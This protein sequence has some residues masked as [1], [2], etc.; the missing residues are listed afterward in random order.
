MKKST[1]R[2][3]VAI[4]SIAI[5]VSVSLSGCAVQHDN[6]IVISLGSEPNSLD[7]AISLTTDA[8]SYI[9]C[10][11]EG[12]LNLDE[13][14]NLIDGAADEWSANST[15]TEYKFHIREDAH[16][17][18]GEKL[19]AEDFLYAWL[20][21]LAPETASGWASFLYYIKNAAA[22]NAGECTAEEVGV[23]AED[24]YL[25]V[26]MESPCA[27]FASMTAIQP[28]FPVYAKSIEEN[29]A[30]WSNHANSLISN[31]AFKLKQWNH[32]NNIVIESNK[33]YWDR[34]KIKTNEIRFDLLE[35]ASVAIN[36]YEA[37][38]LFYLENILTVNEMAQIDDVEVDDYTVTKFLS[39]NFR[40]EKFF[41]KRVREAITIALD[42][43]QLSVLIG[44]GATPLCSFIP[45]GFTNS[46]LQMDFRKDGISPEKYVQSTAEL[47]RARELLLQ[48]GYSNSNQLELDYLTN[49]SS[50]NVALAEIVKSQLSKVGIKV[51]II[52][53]ESKVFNDRRVLRDFDIVASSWAAEYPDISSYLYGFQASDFNNYANYDNAEYDALYKLLVQ[54]NSAERFN[55]IHQAEDLIMEDVAAIPLFSKNKT[56]ISQNGIKGYYHDITG[57]AIFRYVWKG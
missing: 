7:P 52:A 6:S 32:D 34:D 18:N 45:Y 3:L 9:T 24:N 48:A 49:T 38:Q 26:K 39:L 14:G 4:L 54:D 30:A 53:L 5:C 43:E 40:R 25:T 19:V 8:R 44:D 51:N 46:T 22:Y 42:R 33:Y 57:C 20:R 56:F 37:G 10:M 55:Y 13:S 36:A 47:G 21:V 31:G 12:L 23:I 1:F 35:N 41:D 16:W 28:Y 15:N 2:L 27:F 17:S 29:G 11:F 50:Q